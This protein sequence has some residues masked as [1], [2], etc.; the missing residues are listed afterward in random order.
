MFA[1]V[2]TSADTIVVGPG[3]QIQRI[4]DA[5]RIA[6]DGDTA[7]IMPGEYRGDVIVRD[8]VFAEAPQHASRLSHLLYVGQIARLEVSGS[9]FHSGIGST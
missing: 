2:T 3:E 7:L 6:Q 1:C 4:G 8:S 5:A 9:R